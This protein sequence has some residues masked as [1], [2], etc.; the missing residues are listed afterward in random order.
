MSQDKL[1]SDC[2]DG[3]HCDTPPQSANFD[4]VNEDTK[5]IRS[6]D[7]SY[8]NTVTSSTDPLTN[9][10]TISEG[11]PFEH[12]QDVANDN[13]AESPFIGQEDNQSREQNF[14]VT[15]VRDV[16]NIHNDVNNVSQFEASHRAARS[17]ELL[18]QGPT[19]SVEALSH[20]ASKSC[21][22]LNQSTPHA[23]PSEEPL[24]QG[25]MMEE[26]WPQATSEAWRIEDC[27]F[28]SFRWVYLLD[29]G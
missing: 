22:I 29:V 8:H 23:Y 27:G 13:E 24:G 11:N 18:H 5:L 3:Y 1:T 4:D 10:D 2:S 21:E 26:F 12:D 15:Y 7:V 9:Y 19:F 6:S 17:C 14:D 28:E 20:H 16:T 25:L